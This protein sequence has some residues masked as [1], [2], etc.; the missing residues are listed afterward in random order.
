VTNRNDPL[1]K[2]V[3]HCLRKLKNSYEVRYGRSV[4]SNSSGNLLSVKV[5]LVH[6]ALIATGLFERV[7]V[8][9][10]YVLDEGD[11]KGITIGQFLYKYRH[12]RESGANRSAESTLTS[13][14]LIPSLPRPNQDRLEYSKRSNRLRK[15]ANFLLWKVHSRLLWIRRDSGNIDVLNATVRVCRSNRQARFGNVFSHLREGLYWWRCRRH[16]CGR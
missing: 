8:K 14:D 13:N 3:L 7:Q 16:G 1:A 4:L 10:L 9:A 2:V 6:E 12:L 5:E 15:F 11:L